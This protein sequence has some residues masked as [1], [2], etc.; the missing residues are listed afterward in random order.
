M[1]V[2]LESVVELR[3]HTVDLCKRLLCN[4]ALLMLMRTRLTGVLKGDG[5]VID[6][7]R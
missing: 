1:L 4:A 2:L 5:V 3:R 7:H 6:R